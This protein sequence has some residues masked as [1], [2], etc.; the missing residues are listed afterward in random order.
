[1]V[2]IGITIPTKIVPIK[3]A[4]KNNINGSIKAT[5]VLSCWSSS[6]S[7][8]SARRI[9]SLSSRLLSSATEIISTVAP[10][11]KRLQSP[12]LRASG[13]PFFTRSMESL[14]A[15]VRIWLPIE[16]CATLSPLTKGTPAWISV[17]S[18]LEKRAMANWEDR[19][20]ITG[21]VSSQRS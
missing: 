3:A 11:N 19:G 13:S 8:T 5:A 2:K 1:M 4:M 7:V 14:M 18:I 10:E 21:A 15:S 20:P 17:P 12:R 16:R 9:S 6:F